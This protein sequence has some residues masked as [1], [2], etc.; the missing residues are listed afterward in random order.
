[1]GGLAVKNAGP[2]SMVTGEAVVADRFVLISSSTLKYAD[3]GE[4]PIGLTQ[5]A[6]ASGAPCAYEFLDSGIH[7][8]TGSKAITAG[9]GIYVTTDGKVSDAAVGKQI[10]VLLDVAITGDG[11]KAGA[12]IWGPRGGNDVLAAQSA[13]TFRI[14]DHFTSGSIEDGG[15]FSETADK[16]VW[17]KS[18]TDGSA[19]TVDVC[20]VADD[21]PGGIWQLTCN[22]A[23][24]DME[25]VQM[26][27]ESVKLAVGKKVFY[28]TSLALLDVDKCDFF[29]GLAISDVDILGGVT[30]RIG[31]Q[32]LH[33][34]NI[35]CLVEQDD[36]E[37]L[38]DTLVDIE[39]CAA[40]GNFASK[41]VKLAFLWDGV[42]KVYF[43]VNGV[44]KSTMTDNSTTIVVPDDET[45]S[46]VYQIKTYTGASAVQ[47]MF[48]DYIDIDGEV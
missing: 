15:K 33:D 23:N 38:E 34:G 31:F 41:K 43:F 48:C 27:G 12:I 19:G 46:P 32:V 3:G 9:S 36:T 45:L 21:G 29:C 30:D 7:K 24:A 4:E 42:D 14:R 13:N 25:N 16:A 40:I 10:G 44:L 2:G 8:V 28:E 20:I 1:M 5:E 6:V 39:D 11:G 35:K 26:N 17:L 37:N 18:S 22:A 47:T